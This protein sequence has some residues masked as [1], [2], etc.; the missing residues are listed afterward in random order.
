MSKLRL[1]FLAYFVAYSS[2][3]AGCAG[4]P[5]PPQRLVIHTDPSCRLIKPRSY[6]RDGDTDLSVQYR[7]DDNA[8]ACTC[9]NWRNTPACKK[10]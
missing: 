3:L 10:V 1:G 7:R 6:D 4:T 9:S 2:L 8:A 5:P